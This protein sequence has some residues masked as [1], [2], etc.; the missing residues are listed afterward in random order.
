MCC[1]DFQ[2]Q[3]VASPK[4]TYYFSGEVGNRRVLY[5]ARTSNPPGPRPPFCVQTLQVD[6]EWLVVARCLWERHLVFSFEEEDILQ[7]GGRRYS[8]ASRKK[9]FL[10]AMECVVRKKNGLDISTSGPGRPSWAWERLG[11]GIY[12]NVSH[13]LSFSFISGSMAKIHSYR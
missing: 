1:F 6:P 11:A 7:L 3:P 8:S 2:S 9:I 5:Q 12:L 4:L 13:N 10:R